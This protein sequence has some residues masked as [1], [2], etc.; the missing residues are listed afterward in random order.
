LREPV[1][2]ISGSL[3]TF[4]AAF[5]DIDSG[6]NLDITSIG[7]LPTGMIDRSTTP[8]SR[9]GRDPASPMEGFAH[10]LWRALKPTLLPDPRRPGWPEQFLRQACE[11][12]VARLA[13]DPRSEPM[14]GRSLFSSAR[15]LMRAQDQ[16]LASQIIERHLAR[17]RGYFEAERGA[18]GLDGDE[19]RCA[20]L[21]RKG[22]PCGRE[23]I[24]GT[25]YCVSHTP[26]DRGAA[27]A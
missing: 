19:A 7:W 12:G 26:R 21:N 10:D 3:G 27:T 13:A 1:G 17:A 25:P 23:P 24:W 8:P 11:A 15:T 4:L 5:S 14:A 2:D 16:L 22:K 20:A 9:A 18:V 6:Q